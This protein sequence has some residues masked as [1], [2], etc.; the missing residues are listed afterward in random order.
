[1]PTVQEDFEGLAVLLLGSMEVRWS[2]ATLRAETRLGFPTR[3]AESLFAY[4]VLNRGRLLSRD[5]VIGALWGELNEDTARKRLRTAL[6]R[7]RSTLSEI[8]PSDRDTDDF[9]VVARDRI[10]FTPSEHHWVDVEQFEALARPRPGTPDGADCG[11]RLPCL[12]RAMELYRGDLLEG[13]YAEWCHTERTRLQAHYLDAV[14]RL[15]RCYATTGAWS[16]A[17]DCGQRILSVDPLRE[18]V[19]RE[20]MA[21]YYLAGDRPRALRQFSNCEQT[22]RDELGVDPMRSTRQLLEA[23]EAEDAEWLAAVACGAPTA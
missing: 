13:E 3:Q 10:G 12:R 11:A 1:M 17:L 23:L 2:S 5:V 18:K 7:V 6:W 8:L 9:V 4:L 19:H 16:E 21:L 22:L 15:M 14:E 20:V